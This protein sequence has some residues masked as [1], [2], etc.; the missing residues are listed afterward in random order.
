MGCC[1]D[2]PTVGEAY[3]VDYNVTADGAPANAAA[4]TCTVRK[5]D[6]TTF[7]PPVG[8]VSVGLYRVEGYADQSGQWWF[9]FV[10]AGPADVCE[11]ALLVGESAVLA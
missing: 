10:A 9:R 3:S 1:S 7:E 8:N 6:G 5:P 4:V 11:K 2:C